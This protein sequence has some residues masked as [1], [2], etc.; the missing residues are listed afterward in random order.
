MAIRAVIFDVGN[1][2]LH[3]NYTVIAEVLTACGYTV[4]SAAV[5]AAEC[6][7]RP[8]LDTLIIRGESSPF[9]GYFQALCTRLGLPWDD[10]TRAALEAIRAYDRAHGLWD[11]ALPRAHATLRTL[12]QAGYRLGVIS[13]S[14]GSAASLLARQGLDRFFR[15]VLDS[16][17]V[18]VEKPAPRIFQLALEHIGTA[19]QE[20]VY[21]GDLYCVDVAGARGVGMHGVLLDP[22]AVWQTWPC[23]KVRDLQQLPSL[24]TTLA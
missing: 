13:N 21:V 24:L 20:T 7:A 1:T 8:I 12:Q 6:Y 23:P 17:L 15:F 18:K 14:D 3:M 11:Q 19:P 4:T 9:T 22:L 16:F 10:K 2:L 5:Y